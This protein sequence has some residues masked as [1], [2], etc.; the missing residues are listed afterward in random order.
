LPSTNTFFSKRLSQKGFSLFYFSSSVTLPTCIYLLVEQYLILFMKLEFNGTTLNIPTSWSDI[1]LGEYEKWFMCEPKEQMEYVEFVANIC[2]VD[3][4]ILLQSPA[5]VF[6]IMIDALSF[7]SEQDFAPVNYTEI[8]G[9]KY[10]VS[11][12]DELTL[13][14]WVDVESVLESESETK[15]SEILAILCRP[16][17]EKYDTQ[18]ADLRKDVFR[19]LPCDKVLPLIAF[20][21]FKKKQSEKISNLCSTV[22]D[23][24]DQLVRDISHFAES[25]DGIKSLPI[26][27]RIKYYFLTRY[28]KKRL[29]K[30]SDSFSTEW[31]KPQPKKSRLSFFNRLKGRFCK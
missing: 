22:K 30:F 17:G 11:F 10:F 19:N 25:G 24:T 31:I 26:W 9:K 5:Q 4:Q 2:K 29:S 28:L 18:T 12:S 21:L 15:I 14:E 27:Q 3:T 16:A 8:D 7:I 23:R 13:A 20:F 6:S 1:K